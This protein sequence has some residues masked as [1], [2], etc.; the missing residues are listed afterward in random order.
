MLALTASSNYE[1][2]FSLNKDSNGTFSPSSI[3]TSGSNNHVG[4][5]TGSNIYADFHNHPSGSPPSA[6]DII[7]LGGLVGGDPP[8][9]PNQVASFTMSPDS[10][11]YGLVIVDKAKY[12]TFWNANNNA[13]ASNNGWNVNSPIGLKHLEVYTYFENQP[14]I[15]AEEAYARATA[16]ILKD[17]G[18]I[19]VKKGAN[20]N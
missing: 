12:E 13:V 7:T 2:Y 5:N 15:S 16:F 19:L 11:M 18:V 17:A 20:S 3:T 8:A 1:H 14:S 10:T 4:G 6:R 9:N